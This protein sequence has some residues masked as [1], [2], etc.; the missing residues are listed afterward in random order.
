MRLCVY[1]KQPLTA[2]GGGGGPISVFALAVVQHSTFL[3]D[4]QYCDLRKPA[5]QRSALSLSCSLS[6]LSCHLLTFLFL[7]LPSS[8]SLTPPCFF[9]YVDME[10]HLS[11]PSLSLTA[12][13]P[14]FC[15]RSLDEAA[16]SQLQILAAVS[17]NI[18]DFTM[19]QSLIYQYNTYFSFF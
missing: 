13:P 3:C 18:Q 16:F 7:S 5:Q 1:I 9:S 12:I 17:E 4:I 14:F 8:R 2:I 10:N 15:Q 6:L 19:S 11:I